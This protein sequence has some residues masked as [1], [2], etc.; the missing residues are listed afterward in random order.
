MLNAYS[1]VQTGFRSQ[2]FPVYLVPSAD[3][4]LGNVEWVCNMEK[5]LLGGTIFASLLLPPVLPF[6]PTA[7]KIGREQG[8][9]QERQLKTVPVAET[10]TYMNPSPCNCLSVLYTGDLNV[11]KLPFHS[12]LVIMSISSM[13]CARSKGT[14]VNGKD[15]GSA[16]LGS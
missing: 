12:F 7:S 13:C 8:S 4:T 15:T 1:L 9:G 2:F 10:L 16:L 11:S 14:T 5:A 6:N 3:L